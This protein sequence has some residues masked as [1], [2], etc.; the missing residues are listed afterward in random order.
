MKV[1]Q[2]LELNYDSYYQKCSHIVR[3]YGNEIF[4]S[5]TKQC[6]A[7]LDVAPFTSFRLVWL[8]ANMDQTQIMDSDLQYKV[9]SKSIHRQLKLLFSMKRDSKVGVFD[10]GL[11]CPVSWPS[12]CE[13]SLNMLHTRTHSGTNVSWTLKHYGLLHLIIKCLFIF[14]IVYVYH[15]HAYRMT[16]GFQ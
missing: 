10:F 5:L 8:A 3:T 12:V 4:I 13:S 1:F 16:G 15:F 11:F 7:V 9:L 14:I 2:Y 6:E